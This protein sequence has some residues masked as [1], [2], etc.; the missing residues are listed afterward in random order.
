MSLAAE[1]LLLPGTEEPGRERRL[2]P[3][4]RPASRR[5]PKLV[6]AI[7]ALAGAGLIGIAQIAL[8]IA[9]T[10]DSFTVAQ[11]TQQNKELTW[12]GQA[13]AEELAGLSSP[14]S[15]AAAAAD[16][17]LVVGGS[18]NYIRLS[19]GALIGAGEGAGYASTV[20]PRGSGAVPNALVSDTPEETAGAPVSEG[21]EPVTETPDTNVPPQAEG[22]P[23]PSFGGT[24]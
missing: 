18:A 11:L 5:R 23:T 21:V 17:G 12:Q 20:N 13:A 2:R 7:V 8:S 16:L 14:Q 3:L 1:P 6:Y 24:E 22:L 4:E 15:L 9:T 10:Q 19:D